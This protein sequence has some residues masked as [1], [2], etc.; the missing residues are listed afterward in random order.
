MAAGNNSSGNTQVSINAT[1]TSGTGIIA[2]T[3]KTEIDLIAPTID[4][5]DY[6]GSVASTINIGSGATT[7]GKAVNI[8]TNTSSGTNTINIGTGAASA[9]TFALGTLG[10]TT[11]D[12]NTG[13]TTIDGST[14]SIDGTSSSNFTVT[15]GTVGN[16]TTL[17]LKA[18]NTAIS[19]VSSAS[20]DINA[21]RD[22]G[23]T[24]TASINLTATDSIT[25]TAPAINIGG[26]LKTSSTANING[27]F[28]TS[29]TT[30]TGTTRL[31][32]SGNLYA[33][34]FNA[35]TLTAATNGFTIAGGTT[36]KTLTVSD[37][38]TLAT[39]AITFASAKSVTAQYASLTVGASTL[40]GDITLKSNGTY[41]RSL[42]LGE[43]GVS[44]DFAIK[45]LTANHVLYASAANTIDS[46][47]YLDISRGGTGAATAAGNTV[48]GS[49]FTNGANITVAYDNVIVATNTL[50]AI[51]HGLG[52]AGTYVNL[53]YLSTTGAKI[54]GLTLG[55]VYYVKIVDIDNIEFVT[56]GVG[57][58]LLSVGASGNHV[59]VPSLT[60]AP[61]F[62]KLANEDLPQSGVS[63][64]TYSV[65]AVNAKGLVTGGGQ[66]MEMG[67]YV[68]SAGETTNRPSAALAVGGLFFEAMQAVG[69]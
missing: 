48:F 58:P 23:G 61:S 65:V 52:T 30:P 43:A 49:P 67:Y 55:S 47:A 59:F 2:L 27:S 34:K 64:G 42:T 7:G 11:L 13:S 6:T 31:N 1:S 3:G 29:A 51:S 62:R 35:L 17:T 4:I 9:A 46:E 26:I 53:K 28:D 68:S 33:N 57:T 21:V 8:A 14:I 37:S 39:N 18:E 19:G 60:S 54:G 66:L 12:I 5:A 22:T 24:G 50:H 69:A 32:Y 41:A 45:T 40:T 56:L 20:V 63:A 44:E 38:T 16:D 15:E 25:A 36:S 10:Y